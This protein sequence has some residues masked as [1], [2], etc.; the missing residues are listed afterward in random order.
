M[1]SVVKLKQET[2]SY[3]AWLVPVGAPMPPRSELLHLLLYTVLLNMLHWHGV[4]VHTKILD[5]ALNNTMRIVTG[6]LRPTPTLSLP[7]LAGIAPAE[8]QRD[9]SVHKLATQAKHFKLGLSWG[10]G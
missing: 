3:A 6:C 9:V 2:I 5:I 1:L 7:T 10:Y 8:L 4:V